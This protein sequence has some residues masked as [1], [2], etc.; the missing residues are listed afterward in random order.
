MLQL[1]KYG[2]R[3]N[4]L[5]SLV[6]HNESDMK[7]PVSGFGEGV[8]GAEVCG[9]MPSLLQSEVICVGSNHEGKSIK[10]FMKFCSSFISCLL[11]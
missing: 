9:D 6:S 11:V 7:W 3:W 4:S 1:S 8:G 10:N 2:K 5:M